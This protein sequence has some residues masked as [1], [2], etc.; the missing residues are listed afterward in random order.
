MFFV[1]CFEAV[2]EADRGVASALAVAKHSVVLQ[3]FQPV[4]DIVQGVFEVGDLQV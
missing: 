3:V 1:D 2:E 4:D